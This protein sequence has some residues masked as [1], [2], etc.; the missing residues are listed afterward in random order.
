[1]SDSFVNGFIGCQEPFCTFQIKI[2]KM[3]I[4]DKFQSF[5]LH[6]RYLTLTKTTEDIIILT[7]R[8]A[9][10]L[11]NRLYMWCKL[12]TI[13]FLIITICLLAITACAEKK[14][15]NTVSL[16][17]EPNS[18]AA[19]EEDFFFP[20]LYYP[21]YNTLSF[22]TGSGYEFKNKNSKKLIITLDGGPSWSGHMGK[23]GDKI[24]GYWLIEQMLYLY[25]EYNFFVPTRFNWEEVEPL[26][27][28]HILSERERYTIDNLIINYKEVISEYLSQNDYDTIIIAGQSE[29][30]IVLPILYSCLADFNISALISI[31]GSG[32]SLYEDYEIKTAKLKE[33]KAPY[34]SLS[35]DAIMTAINFMEAILDAYHEEP[36]PDSIRGFSFVRTLTYKY[37]KSILFIRPFD[38]YVDINIPVL[39]IHGER[40]MNIAVESTRYIEDNLP[41]KPFNYIY[42]Q[43]ME[44]NPTK[45]EEIFYMF[46]NDIKEWLISKGL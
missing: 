3:E 1:M 32:L 5:I 12:K 33:G 29:G 13:A 20:E 34:N 27:Y 22:S 19:T 44:H 38:Y 46:Q 15:E 36:Y 25:D 21:N 37:L 16:E 17:E 30:A 6:S 7:K 43:E 8:L 45:S 18:T 40:D 24:P 23:P 14:A 2:D 26:Y 39:F 11:N 31:S 35:L 10:R 9:L 4:L 42:Y 28:Y 41:G